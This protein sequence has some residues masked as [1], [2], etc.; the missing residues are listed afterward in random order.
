MLD[1]RVDQIAARID[2]G[3]RLADIESELIEAARELD[4]DERA[5]LWLFAW[6]YRAVPPELRAP[7]P[8]VSVS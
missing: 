6:S 5:A 7:P 8:A 3:M 2:Q 1:E 4:E